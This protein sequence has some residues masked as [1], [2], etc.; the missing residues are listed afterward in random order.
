MYRVRLPSVTEETWTPLT[1]GLSVPE[2]FW[3]VVV[4]GEGPHGRGDREDGTRTGREDETTDSWRSVPDHD[5]PP[6][7]REGVTF[8]P[9]PPHSIIQHTKVPSLQRGAFY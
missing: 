1:P 2:G 7:A 5:P 9:G 6:A 8:R 3:S 4:D